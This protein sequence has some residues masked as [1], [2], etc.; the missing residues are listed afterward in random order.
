MII[1]YIQDVMLKELY[2]LIGDYRMIKQYIISIEA[3]NEEIINQ[4]IETFAG[5]YDR[6][7]NDKRI[8]ATMKIE[9]IKND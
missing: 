2:T 5:T 8:P 6:M 7:S 3:D 9:G 1:T 4:L